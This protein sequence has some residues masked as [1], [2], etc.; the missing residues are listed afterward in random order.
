AC[1][2]RWVMTQS[3][4]TN[5]VNSNYFRILGANPDATRNP[6]LPV[7]IDVDNLIDYML[8]IFYSGDGDATLSS[9]LGNNMPN[10]WFGMRDRTNPDVGFRFFNSDCEHT[11]GSPNSPVD[12][13]GT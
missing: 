11:L 6:S 1:A 5:A 4:R 2:N 10:N 12:R 3:M 13:N 7:M 9:F 8:E